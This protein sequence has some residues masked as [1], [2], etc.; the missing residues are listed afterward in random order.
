MSGIKISD[1]PQAQEALG[2][3][4]LEVNDS[5]TS[6]RVS[7]EQVKEY[8][9]TTPAG[10]DGALQFNVDGEFF[11]SSQF[12]L[13]DGGYRLDIGSG[14]DTTEIQNNRVTIASEWGGSFDR[15]TLYNDSFAMFGRRDWDDVP[16]YRFGRYTNRSLTFASWAEDDSFYRS[17][18]IQGAEGSYA[19]TLTLPDGPGEEGQ[20]LQSDGW[21]NLSWADA[22]GGGGGQGDKGDKGD[23]GDPGDP[24][25]G[26]I[27]GGTSGQVLA[28]A[29]NSDYDTEWVTPSGTSSSLNLTEDNPP[30]PAPDSVTLFRRNAGGRQMP[31]FIGP[32]GLSTALQPLI[33]RNKIAWANPVGNSTILS[34]VGTALVATGTATLATVATT[35]IHTAIRRL[36]Y[37]ATVDQAPNV[38]GFRSASNVYHIGDPNTPFGGFFMVCRFGPS[39]G[40]ASNATRRGFVG[41][42]STTT[43]PTDAAL[44]QFAN[45][46]GVGHDSTDTN[47]QIVHRTGTG[48]IVKTDTGIPKAYPD[49]SEMFE[50]TLFTSPGGTPTVYYEFRRLSDNTRFTGAITSSLPAATALMGIQAYNAVGGT[51][52][53]I[54]MSLA[55]LY[56]ETDY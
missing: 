20:F 25:V 10:P 1:L 42:S 36:E 45:I 44:T 38:A 34:T 37:A 28:K 53:V 14:T 9:K 39:R 32:S 21:G 33:A 50:L 40:A 49:N 3:M 43:A 8:A 13:A 19:Y 47:W 31:A 18:T 24:G 27:A 41:F 48:P 52:S 16:F 12:S 17:V 6:R 46:L 55:S 11:G 5:G 4:D 56:I 35:N 22:V 54:G 7:V 51:S 29:S 30:V 26:V 15:S 23:K 2:S